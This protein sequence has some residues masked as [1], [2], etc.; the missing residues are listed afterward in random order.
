LKKDI[1]ILLVIHTPP[2]YGGGE[3]QAQNLKEY[4]SNK[5]GYY[6][7]DY[8]RKSLT[9]KNQGIFGLKN[10]SFGIFWIIKTSYLLVKIRPDKVYF[11]LPKGYFAFLRNAVII[12]IAR[13]LNIETLGELPGTSFLFLG[14]KKNYKYRTG[15]YYLKKVSE[16][17][18]LGESIRKMHSRYELN[19]GV[20]ID[21]G[22]YV[23]SNHFTQ[24]EVFKAK[25]LKLIYLGS[26]EYSKGIFNT[27]K[28]VKMCID[29]NIDVSFDVIGT[30]KNSLEKYEVEAYITQYD[31]SDVI[32]FHG[33]KLDNEK[34]DI[35]STCAIL[36]HPTYW[37]GVPLTILEAFCLGLCVISTYIG[38]IPDIM[39]N[40]INGFLIEE[41]TPECI[42]L[43]ISKCY[44]NREKLLEISLSN[45]ELYKSRFSLDIFLSNMKTWFEKEI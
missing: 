23:P 15:L 35:F 10:I 16:I 19:N 31:L 25:T 13:M 9:R 44:H 21:N 40:K 38:G 8:S 18:F 45:K 12:S 42:Y 4:F 43:T 37:D 29:N 7:Y 2:P 22:V 6:I 1:R 5:D 20:V 27:I 33:Q 26:I 3:I 39:S 30:W 34:W 14:N 24:P 11:T 41:N 17:R 28:A 32:T 36:V